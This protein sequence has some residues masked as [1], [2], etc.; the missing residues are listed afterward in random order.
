M[1]N[2]LQAPG[3]FFFRL[4]ASYVSGTPKRSLHSSRSGGIHGEDSP[5]ANPKDYSSNGNNKKTY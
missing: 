3:F 2:H 4:G 5:L 1:E